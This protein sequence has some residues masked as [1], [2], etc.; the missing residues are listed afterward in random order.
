MTGGKET[1]EKEKE[2]QE[3]KISATEK[4]ILSTTKTRP[5]VSM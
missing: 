1:E 4:N 3:I 5:L 2:G